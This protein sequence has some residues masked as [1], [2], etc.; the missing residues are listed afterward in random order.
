MDKAP[1]VIVPASPD[2]VAGTVGK[3]SCFE[4][5]CIAVTSHGMMA[6]APM[7]PS[8]NQNGSTRSKQAIGAWRVDVASCGVHKLGSRWRTGEFA[9][10]TEFA[11]PTSSAG[12]PS[13][14]THRLG[15]SRHFLLQSGQG[16]GRIHN[17]CMP[18]GP[19]RALVSLQR[20]GTTGARQMQRAAPHPGGYSVS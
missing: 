17:R 19:I 8:L 2:V 13:S 7:T 14:G 3:P 16:T 12:D 10:Q 20:W 18:C 11:H 6:G 5:V 15:G 1:P 4:L 9:G